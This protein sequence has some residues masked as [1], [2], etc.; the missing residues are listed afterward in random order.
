MS[1]PNVVGWHQVIKHS[2][3][4]AAGLLVRLFALL[5][6]TPAVA[7]GQPQPALTAEQLA[8]S[9]RLPDGSVVG[10]NPF[11]GDSGPVAPLF[12]DYTNGT[13]RTLLP[14]GGDRFGMGPS[15][16]AQ[17]PT[18]RIV[19]VV[20]DSSGTIT[21]IGLQRP[22]ED[23][24]LATRLPVEARDISFSSEDATLAGTLLLPTTRG[25]H[26]A[27]ILLHGSG[28]LA[29]FSF[30]P[31]PRFFSSLGFAVLIYDK[32]ATG[33]STGTFFPR[34][35]FYPEPYLRDA[36]A[37]VKFL[38][39]RGDIDPNQIGVWG[40]SEGGMLTTQLAAIEGVAFA[41]NSSGFMMPLWE[42]V[43]Y[44]I[45][46]QLRGDGFSAI[47]VA[48]AVRFETL[49]IEVM[50]TGTNWEQYE[51]AQTVALRQ[52]WWPAYFGSSKGFSSLE[53]LRW[54]WEHV[55][56][57]DP[58][59]ALQAV[60]CPVLALFGALDTSTPAR[61]AGD[62]LENGLRAAGNSDVTIRLF[63]QANH[64]L[65]DARTGGN[66]EIP[67]L[68]RMVPDVFQTIRTWLSSRIKIAPSQ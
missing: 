5:L 34:T 10:I 62:N 3:R 52:K 31:Y 27:I 45:E 13:I 67:G 61:Q 48:D 47:E 24:V 9:Y 38:K 6:V 66:A 39:S 55:Y 14:L 60:K 36:V 42:Q 49:A 64:P 32:R 19:R 1:Y 35:A 7:R 68:T 21:G 23:E 20:R 54:Q 25:P 46:A 51:K 33:A 18:E 65:M 16:G 44:N 41:I 26:P 22:N 12:T 8:G 57:F 59:S 43:L 15:L 17:S 63:A 53:N 58:R 40:T 2:A 50:R 30:G 37:A 28:Q 29:R 11:S 4:L 56:S